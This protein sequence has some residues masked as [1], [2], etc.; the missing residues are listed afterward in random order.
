MNLAEFYRLACGEPGLEVGDQRAEAE[1]DVELEELV[2]GQ[3]FFTT[4][5]GDQL[6]AML[7]AMTPPAGRVC[8]PRSGPTPLR[9]SSPFSNA[10]PG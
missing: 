5:R 3:S 7:L 4:Q 6:S 10:C 1:D 2:R 9:R 8:L